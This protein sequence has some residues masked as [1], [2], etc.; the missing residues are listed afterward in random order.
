MAAG[1][2]MLQLLRQKNLALSRLQAVGASSGFSATDPSN[3]ALAN[4]ISK[5]GTYRK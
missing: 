4:E 1:R 3:L 2:D 5:Y